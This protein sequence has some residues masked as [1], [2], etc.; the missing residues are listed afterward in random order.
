MQSLLTG[1]CTAAPF[2]ANGHYTVQD[3]LDLYDKCTEVEWILF[4]S[5]TTLVSAKRSEKV[6]T[7]VA[8]ALSLVQRHNRHM[9]TFRDLR[10]ILRQQGTLTSVADVLDF[11]C[12]TL[13]T[14]LP[15]PPVLRRPPV[16]LPLC[17]TL[18]PD[19]FYPEAAPH[20]L[21]LALLSRSEEVAE[22]V[23]QAHTSKRDRREMQQLARCCLDKDVVQT[24]STEAPCTPLLLAGM[25]NP[26]LTAEKSRDVHHSVW[27]VLLHAYLQRMCEIHMPSDAAATHHLSPHCTLLRCITLPVS[28]LQLFAPERTLTRM[29][30]S[31]LGSGSSSIPATV[32]S[33]S[34]LFGSSLS[35]STIATHLSTGTGKAGRSVPLFFVM[36][37]NMR[38]HISKKER[39][40]TLC[41]MSEAATV[42]RGS[43]RF[44]H[45]LKRKSLQGASG[46]SGFIVC[47]DEFLQHF[48]DEACRDSAVEC[49]L[50][51][52]E[53]NRE[54]MRQGSV[55]HFPLCIVQFKRS[56]SDSPP[57]IPA[58]YSVAWQVVD[59]DLEQPDT[60]SSFALLMGKSEHCSRAEA[61]RVALAVAA[62]MAGNSA[63]VVPRLRIR[64]FSSKP[65]L[66]YRRTCR[67]GRATPQQ[68]TGIS[69]NTM[70]SA[71]IRAA[72]HDERKRVSVLFAVNRPWLCT[73]D[74]ESICMFDAWHDCR[75]ACSRP[76][77]VQGIA[78]LTRPELHV[79]L[80]NAW[81]WCADTQ[82]DTRLAYW[83]QAAA[84]AMTKAATTR[85]LA[86]PV[87]GVTLH[88]RNSLNTGAWFV[89]GAIANQPLQP[90]LQALP[91]IEIHAAFL[92]AHIPA[93]LDTRKQYSDWISVGMLLYSIDH[94]SEWLRLCYRW[95]SRHTLPSS[96]LEK[97]HVGSHAKWKAL[98]RKDGNKEPAEAMRVLKSKVNK[99][100]VP[101]DEGKCAAVLQNICDACKEWFN[102]DVLAGK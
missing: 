65:V 72:L 54:V 25:A 35:S 90:A 44:V 56:Y 34:S 101:V 79:L 71:V 67:R 70:C 27:S 10:E 8:R 11:S 88:S 83:I 41:S 61:Y 2:F 14:K 84:P 43:D 36:P 80:Y 12:K 20:P 59:T 15:M 31:S 4:F 39:W 66:P 49:L 73:P 48:L 102:V 93:V 98:Q 42:A 28:R 81:A 99:T 46:Q 82:L 30:S 26:R 63:A 3:A 96:Y 18:A 86:V 55:C 7:S 51:D 17:P 52:F 87:H 50:F 29:I 58:G 64:M 1:S 75:H 24:L 33:L 22:M 78:V 32:T 47:R 40:R 57:H 92:L 23:A 9:L 89:P 37:Q 19:T 21:L 16:L 38:H 69:E 53:A 13:P 94:S 91:R 62:N 76:L 95:W 74:S 5:G 45:L 97:D 100:G 60:G 6:R 85:K 77:V 68:P